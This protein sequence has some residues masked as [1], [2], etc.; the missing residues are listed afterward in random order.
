MSQ[1]WDARNAIMPGLLMQVCEAAEDSRNTMKASIR[2]MRVLESGRA[3]RRR[4]CWPGSSSYLD[5]VNPEVRD[6]WATNF[7]PGR[8]PGATKHL[9][10]WNDM[11]EPSVF[12]GPEVNR[13]RKPFPPTP[14]RPFHRAG[15]KEHHSRPQTPAL[16]TLSQA[17]AAHLTLDSC[18]FPCWPQYACRQLIPWT[19][20]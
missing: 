13:C 20:A 14:P 6:W 16:R 7:L 5:V 19:P 9:Y 10:V 1:A 15:C 2:C 4:W 17:H 8:Y 18:S 3:A 11:N 12:N